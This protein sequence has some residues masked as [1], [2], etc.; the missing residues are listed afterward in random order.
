M[1]FYDSAGI[2]RDTSH[3][4]IVK[5]LEALKSS[6]G[7]SPWPVIEEIFKVWQDKRP[8]EWKSHLVY[9][10]EV[11]RTRSNKF[12]SSMPDDVHKGIL[13]YTLDIPEFVM[14]AIRFL[15]TPDELPMTKEFFLEFGKRFQQCKIAEK[16]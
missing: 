5:R 13:R 9:I 10:D 16:N 6:S 11:R 3:F 7:S 1:K 12:A 8:N 15:Y 2:A 4:E 14:K